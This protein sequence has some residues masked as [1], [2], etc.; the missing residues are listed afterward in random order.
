[1]REA[2][3]CG[4]QRLEAER[5]KQP[6]GTGIPRVRND[7]G[8][9]PPV[10]LLEYR[11]FLGLRAHCLSP[12]CRSNST[13]A[14]GGAH[15]LPMH[16]R[17]FDLRHGLASA[18]SWADTGGRT[19]A[20]AGG[21]RNMAYEF[22][23]TERLD[24]CAIITLNRPEKLNALSFPLMTEV[25][26]ALCEYEA[27]EAIKAVILTGAGERAFSAGA[28]IHGMAGL[29]SE[30]L[31]VRGET[32]GRISWHIANYSKPLI[33]AIN[34]LAYGGAALLSSSLDLRIGCETTQLRLLVASSGRV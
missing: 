8:A 13:T 32:R 34:G 10:Q 15:D 6:C 16:N 18:A 5:G 22:I 30:E 26:A 29:S 23:L 2:Q 7:E 27:D 24:G 9:G 4:R 31:A 3:T 11:S 17:L 12:S 1:V 33:G 19:T 14:S 28:D 21:V 25:E 20:I